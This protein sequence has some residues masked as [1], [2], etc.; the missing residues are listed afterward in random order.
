M[1]WAQMNFIVLSSCLGMVIVTAALWY[2]NVPIMFV[3]ISIFGFLLIPVVGVGYT[4]TAM[5]F[6]PISPATSCGI[7]HIGNAAVSFGLAEIASLFV[8]E[9]ANAWY[10]LV[11]MG[12]SG[13]V[14]IV[15]ALLIKVN[16]SVYQD[17]KDIKSVFSVSFTF[18]SKQFP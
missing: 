3:A 5:N 13:L 15:A 7:A 6:L 4:F 16:P 12:A 10:A 11:V 2:G 1:Y 9:G 18:D 14:G 8:E 17:S